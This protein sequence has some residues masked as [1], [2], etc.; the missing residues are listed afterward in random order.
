ME[1]N[2]LFPKILS[3]YRSHLRVEDIV[4]VSI[5]K[6]CQSRHVNANSLTQWMR[7]HGITAYS[8]ECEVLMEKYGPDKAKVL[9]DQEFKR[10]K[11]IEIPVPSPKAPIME[12]KLLRSVSITF[13]DGLQVTIRQTTPAA[14]YRFIDLYNQKIDVSYVRSK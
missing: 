3:A 9:F 14:L 2:P 7:R 8:L 5:N 12:D 11:S 1:S 4:H 10:S 6:F 13:P